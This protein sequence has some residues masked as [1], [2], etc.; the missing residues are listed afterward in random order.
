MMSGRLSENRHRL[1]AFLFDKGRIE[2][3]LKRA[4]ALSIINQ[5][6]RALVTELEYVY[7]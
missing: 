5:R 2:T 1:G 7:A 3:G 6:W 4:L